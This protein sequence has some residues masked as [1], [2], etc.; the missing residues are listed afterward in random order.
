MTFSLNKK[1][2]DYLVGGS[3]F[4]IGAFAFVYYLWCNFNPA[5]ARHR[6][7]ATASSAR[8]I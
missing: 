2:S 5:D 7:G 4:A 6:A 3:Q 8:T 1:R